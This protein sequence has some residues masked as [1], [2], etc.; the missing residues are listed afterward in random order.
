MYENDFFKKQMSL[1]K[2]E[3]SDPVEELAEH[4]RNETEKEREEE[5][6]SDD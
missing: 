2:I 3:F 1:M 4:E 5:M 6:E